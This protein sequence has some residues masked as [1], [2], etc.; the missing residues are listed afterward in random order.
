ME[1]NF[2]SDN[3]PWYGTAQGGT[4]SSIQLAISS[5][6]LIKAYALQLITGRY[7]IPATDLLLTADWM[8]LWMTLQFFWEYASSDLSELLLW[9]QF[10]LDLWQEIL[11]ASGGTLNPP[12]CSWLLFICKFDSLQKCDSVRTSQ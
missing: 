7:I 1:Y 8:L 11:Q 5:D 12:K 10:N 9:L 3:H 6:H 2:F 4:D